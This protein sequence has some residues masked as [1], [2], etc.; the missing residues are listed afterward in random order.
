MKYGV[1][2]ASAKAAMRS[3][4]GGR[5]QLG[6]SGWSERGL[7]TSTVWVHKRHDA[8]PDREPRALDMCQWHMARVIWRRPVE[9]GE[10]PLRA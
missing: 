5:G 4:R 8:G 2:V 3:A 9:D 10:G 1:E 7:L 6:V